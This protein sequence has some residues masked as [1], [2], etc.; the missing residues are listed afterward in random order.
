MN[1][2][3]SSGQLGLSL[4]ARVLASNLKRSNTNH[5]IID[6]RIAYLVIAAFPVQCWALSRSLQ[7]TLASLYSIDRANMD[8]DPIETQVQLR[9]A[10]SPCDILQDRL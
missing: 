2:R 1:S 10:V 5:F 6:S 8:I 9:I 4:F 7:Y 3:Q